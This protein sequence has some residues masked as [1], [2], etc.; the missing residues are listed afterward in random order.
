[1]RLYT[2]IV[3]IIECTKKRQKVAD[4]KDDLMKIVSSG[5]VLDDPETLDAYSKD[6]SFAPQRRPRMVVKPKSA[7][8]VQEI[9]KWANQTGTPLV[10]VSSGQPRFRGDTVPSVGGTVIVDL[11]GMRRIIR[12]D[13]RNRVTIVEPGVTYTQLQPELAKEGLRLSMP[14]L[15]RRSKSVITSLLEREP[16]L[17]PKYQW[18]LLD[19]LRCIE[20]VWGN[21]DIFRTGD[22]GMRGTVEEQWNQFNMQLTPLGPA[23]VD[24]YRLVSASQG[25]MGI[26]TWA[27]LRCEILPQIHKLFFVPSGRL[28]D[29]LDFAYRL[30]RFRFGDELLFLNSSNLAAILAEGIDQVTALRGVLP[31]WVLVV[32]VAGRS[33]L[34]KERV[35]FQEKDIVDIAQQFGLRL[36]T[37]IPGVKDE[38]VL[39]VLLSPSKAPCWRLRYKDGCQDVFFLTT[40]DRTPQ[41]VNTMYSVSQARGYSSSEIGIYIQPVQQGVACHCEFSLPFDPGNQ[42]EVTKIQELLTEASEELMKQGAFFSRPYG[43]WADMVYNR[44][45]QTRILLRKLKAVFDPNNVMN[46]GKLCF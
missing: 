31:P 32:G 24:Y 44:D 18:S 2:G 7:G 34:P 9:V 23:Q 5:N 36:M 6:Q 29:L 26:V 19:P 42:R 33:R 27:S 3:V 14:L 16:L 11:S 39:E 4:K 37:A 45:T 10:P 40:L 28:D 20:V 46:P 41:F 38:Q 21:G 8:E 35:E 25:S 15:P 13:R 43:I 1:M 17:V 12:S 30:L 22:A